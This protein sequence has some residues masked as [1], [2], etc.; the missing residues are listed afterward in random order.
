MTEHLGTYISSRAYDPDR[1]RRVEG[2]HIGQDYQTANDR[3]TVDAAQD[4]TLFLFKLPA[5]SVLSDVISKIRWSALGA[6]VTLSVGFA[7]DA[8]AAKKRADTGGVGITGA[9]RALLNAE[10]A[11]SAGSASM[12]KAIALTD[13]F[14]ELWQLAGL[15]RDPKEEIKI[16][17]T[18]GG[19]N[20]ASGTIAFEQGW[21]SG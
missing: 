15:D 2:Y 9:T 16:I 4:D 13:Q 11:S 8:S 3:F 10:N 20:P 7:D 21:L 5:Q 18:L 17:A 6:G 1:R 12:V 19:A 14:K